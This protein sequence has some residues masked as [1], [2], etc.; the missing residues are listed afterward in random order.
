MRKR[1]KERWYIV[2]VANLCC[3]RTGAK[4]AD[5]KTKASLALNL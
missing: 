5:R 2:L 1:F 3:G 4:G